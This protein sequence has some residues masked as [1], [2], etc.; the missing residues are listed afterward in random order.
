MEKTNISISTD[1]IKILEPKKMKRLYVGPM[2]SGKTTELQRELERQV[3][4]RRKCVIIRPQIDDRFQDECC[5]RSVPL[6]THSL[7]CSKHLEQVPVLRCQTLASIS[8]T[9]MQGHYDAIGIDEAQFFDDVVEVTETWMCE[10]HPRPTIILAALDGDI[11]REPFGQIH[12][13]M[14][15][16]EF[17][18]KLSAVCSLCGNDA[19]FTVRRTPSSNLTGPVVQIGGAETYQ[20]VCRSCRISALSTPTAEYKKTA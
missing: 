6:M 4:A 16:C 7:N 20:A 5:Q 8:L 17:F 10:S 12:R 2:F 3:L 1:P 15:T 14:P 11:N 19:A 9:V 18:K 13:L